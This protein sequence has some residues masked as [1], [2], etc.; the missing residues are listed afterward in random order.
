[1]LK[2]FAAGLD[3]TTRHGEPQRSLSRATAFL[4]G[5]DDGGF[6]APLGE[7]RYDSLELC[8]RTTHDN[9][10]FCFGFIA[11]ISTAAQL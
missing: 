10:G 5:T 4:V 2:E 1:M 11:H 9:D 6:D 7:S 3:I 8:V